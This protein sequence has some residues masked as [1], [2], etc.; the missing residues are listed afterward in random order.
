[1]AGGEISPVSG[2]KGPSLHGDKIKMQQAKAQQQLA[3]R[4]ARQ[5]DTK[6]E[7][8]EWTQLAS[9]NPLKM[10]HEFE[11]LEKRLRQENLQEAETKES[12]ESED[13]GES[14]NVADAAEELA[15]DFSKKNPELNKRTLL[16]VKSHI[17]QDDSEDTILEK[18]TNAY[19]DP[20][21]ADD[22][23]DFIEQSH[24]RNSELAK[25]IAKA[26]TYFNETHRREIIAGKNIASQARDFSQKGL[27]SPTALRDLYRDIT[28]NP[29]D[30]TTLFEELSEHFDYDKLKTIIDF[31]LHSLGADLKSKGP[32]INPA[33]LQRL[34]TESRTMQAIMGTYT[35]FKLRMKLI[36]AAFE[37]EDLTYP[38]RLTFDTLAKQFIK[39]IGERYPSPD[40]VLRLAMILGLSEEL[41]AQSIIFTQYRDALRNVSPRLFKS[42]KHR[43]DLLLS[44]IEALSDLDDEMEEEEEEDDE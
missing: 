32:S 43:Q 35:F 18:V 8:T 2:P 14:A 12:S 9:F 25:R 6:A 20:S 21:L 1:M 15:E 44:T 26:K 3:N 41:M 7:F 13:L 5:A 38:G 28:G 10:S 42:E 17:K 24:V 23:L 16:I 29:R 40:K 11:S 27:G 22:V 39:L 31:V 30:P 34:F 4:V 37:R 33:E 19:S 36:L